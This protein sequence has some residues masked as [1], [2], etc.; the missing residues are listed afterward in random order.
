MNNESQTRPIKMHSVNAAAKASNTCRST[1]YNRIRTGQLRSVKF[2]G[3]RLIPDESLRE[4]L[5]IGE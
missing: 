5:Q 3:R 2:G 4:A 1:I